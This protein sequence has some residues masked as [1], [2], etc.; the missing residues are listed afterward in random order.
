MKHMFVDGTHELFFSYR[1]KPAQGVELPAGNTYYNATV[2]YTSG[3]KV[4]VTLW[5]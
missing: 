4:R 5:C 1:A 3:P 2:T